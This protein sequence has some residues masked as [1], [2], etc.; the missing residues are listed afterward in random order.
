[1]KTKL[2]VYFLYPVRKKSLFSNVV[3]NKNPRLKIHC[4]RLAWAG[5]RTKKSSLGD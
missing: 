5:G 3:Y 4:P 2:H 1:M